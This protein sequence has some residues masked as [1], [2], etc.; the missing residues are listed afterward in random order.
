MVSTL[1][2][3]GGGEGQTLVWNFPHIFFLMGSLIDK[4]FPFGNTKTR[5]FSNFEEICHKTGSWKY[6][7]EKGLFLMNE[8]L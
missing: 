2:A 1:W 8:K 7:K 3:V 6:Q 4:L 5:F